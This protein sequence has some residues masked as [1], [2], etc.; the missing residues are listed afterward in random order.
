MQFPIELQSTEFNTLFYASLI[1]LFTLIDSYYAFHFD[2]IVKGKT[3]GDDAIWFADQ[4]SGKFDKILKVTRRNNII[5]LL[6]VIVLLIK[7][8]THT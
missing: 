1:I 7:I 2:K 6:L 5:C 3:Q 4:S 8:A